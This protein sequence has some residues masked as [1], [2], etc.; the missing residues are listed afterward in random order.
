MAKKRAKHID[1]RQAK[2]E[3]MENGIS[4]KLLSWSPQTM[5]VTVARFEDG[6]KIDETTLPFAHLPRDLKRKVK[7]N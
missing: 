4:Y 1:L 5:S 3:F 6:C 7:P 2:L